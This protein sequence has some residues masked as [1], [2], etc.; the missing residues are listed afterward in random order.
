MDGIDHKHYTE[1]ARRG[2]RGEAYF[3]SL[4]V[5][6]AIPHRIARQNDLGTD[7]LCEWT[8]GDRPTGILF[9]AQVKTSTAE[10]V[11][12]EKVSK[13]PLNL[14]TKYT[15]A[16]IK[17]VDPRT[18]SYWKGLGIPAY[19]FVVVEDGDSVRCF[20]KRYTPLLDG[21]ADADDENG[22]RAFYEVS[23][24]ST[25]LGFASPAEQVGGF[26][27]D[28][29]IDYVRLSYA[30]GVILQ[31]TKK[32]L[33]FWPFK[34]K[35]DEDQLQVF[36]EIVEWNRSKIEEACQTTTKVLAKLKQGSSELKG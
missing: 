28:L 22:T 29:L 1:T 9:S 13:S 3:E 23:R 8:C 2:I 7:F 14:L 24:G 19:L 26:A 4:I 36:G 31:L 34:Y 21:R 15:L 27:R 5:N 11:K 25:F 33:G 6:H 10:S 18:I 32:Q 20:H 16:G 35:G 30:K 17:K 12:C